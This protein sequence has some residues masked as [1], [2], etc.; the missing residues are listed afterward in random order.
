MECRVMASRSSL[1]TR[2]ACASRTER[3]MALEVLGQRRFCAALLCTCH[4]QLPAAQ[5]GW[6]LVPSAPV[7]MPHGD[8]KNQP[9]RPIIKQG[10]DPVGRACLEYNA[11]HG[12]SLRREVVSDIHHALRWPAHLLRVGGQQEGCMRQYRARPG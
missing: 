9:S 6:P 1:V 4:I 2:L 7:A 11:R 12:L 10:C 3:T 8:A 5:A